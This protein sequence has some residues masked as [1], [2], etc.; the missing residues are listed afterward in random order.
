MSATSSTPPTTRAPSGPARGTALTPG[1]LY[2][3]TI[4]ASIPATRLWVSGSKESG[5]W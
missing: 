4:V 1:V 2:L 5:C 3:I